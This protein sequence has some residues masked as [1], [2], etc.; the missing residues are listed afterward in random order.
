MFSFMLPARGDLGQKT[1]DLLT[2]QLADELNK[3]FRGRKE[4][5]L[6]SSSKIR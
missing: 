6:L 1:W 3:G 2:F 4:E 5:E